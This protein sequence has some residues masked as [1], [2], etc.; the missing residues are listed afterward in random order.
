MI[1]FFDA[2]SVPFSGLLVCGMVLGL[3]HVCIGA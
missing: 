2:V 3:G 1:G